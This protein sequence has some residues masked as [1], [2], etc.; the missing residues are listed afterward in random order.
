MNG[1]S[2]L[3]LI[4]KHCE[5]CNADFKVLIVKKL[6]FCSEVCKIFHDEEKERKEEKNKKQ[7]VSFKAFHWKNQKFR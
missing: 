1:L 3:N 2:H 4:K 7:G 5:Y 6:M